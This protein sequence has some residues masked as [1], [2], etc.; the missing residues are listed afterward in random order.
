[1]PVRHPGCPRLTLNRAR[2][3]GVVGSICAP[4]SLLASATEYQVFGNGKIADENTC[5][6]PA[7][8][9]VAALALQES[10]AHAASITIVGTEVRFAPQMLAAAWK[11]FSRCCPSVVPGLPPIGATGVGSLNPTFGASVF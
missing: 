10:A 6:A 3:C 8:P 2:I 1:M 11:T 5:V 4:N 7:L 9:S